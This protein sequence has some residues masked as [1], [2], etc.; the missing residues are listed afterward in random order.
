[1]CP[2]S[3]VNYIVAGNLLTAQGYFAMLLAR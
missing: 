3:P 1:M 2:E